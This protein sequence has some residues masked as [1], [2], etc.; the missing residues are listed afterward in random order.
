YESPVSLSKSEAYR[1]AVPEV[2]KKIT[3]LDLPEDV[4]RALLHRVGRA[5]HNVSSYFLQ[6]GRIGDAW[7][8]HWRSLAWPGGLRYLG[9]TLRLLSLRRSHKRATPHDL[10]PH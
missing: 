6:Q 7:A 4:H 9:Y 8:A 1:L 3:T 2:L 5:Y 10:P